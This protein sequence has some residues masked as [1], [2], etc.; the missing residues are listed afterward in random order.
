M[1]IEKII[2]FLETTTLSVTFSPKGLKYLSLKG[3]KGEGI[4]D[5]KKI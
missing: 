2:E 3:N 5:L 4:I 1:Q